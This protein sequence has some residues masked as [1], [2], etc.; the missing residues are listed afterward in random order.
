MD[1][2]KL[3]DELLRD[4]HLQFAQN[5]N[6]HQ[7]QVFKFFAS[8]FVLIVTFFYATLNQESY[9]INCFSDSSEKAIQEACLAS[10]FFVSNDLYIAFGF[11][12]SSIFALG[13]GYV[14]I[15]AFG[16]RRDQY[17]VRKIRLSTNRRAAA[18]FSSYGEP[19]TGCFWP[20]N[21]FGFLLMT[22][23]FLNALFSLYI[24]FYSPVEV[25]LDGFGWIFF[26][27]ILVKLG[28]YLFFCD[29]HTKLVKKLNK[30]T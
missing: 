30:S 11:I 5:Q 20:P 13:F 21:I 6:H 8:F 9:V 26:F 27:P 17:M 16:F 7:S 23:I 3:G 24:C 25:Y 2:G 10:K 22:I 29:K 4:F 14:V 28:F 1:E 15:I 19:E 18:I 12:I